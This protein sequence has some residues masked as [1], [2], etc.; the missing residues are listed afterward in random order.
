MHEPIGSIPISG[1]IPIFVPNIVFVPRDGERCYG[2]C[3]ACLYA[4]ASS[5]G[6]LVAACPALTG[7]G[8]V[9]AHVS[10]NSQVG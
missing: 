2:K 8:T 5:F 1:S 7:T 4:A 6:G 10:I 3:D 9:H